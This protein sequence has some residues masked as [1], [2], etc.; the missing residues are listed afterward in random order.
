MASI[1]IRIAKQSFVVKGTDG[2]AP[3]SEVADRVQNKIDALL[4]EHPGMTAAK[5]A[6][7]AAMEFAS[8]A[9]EGRRIMDDYRNTILSK[10][11]EIL[12]RIER[13]LTPPSN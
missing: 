3:L 12:E 8:E 4:I 13:E 10:A 7:L 2:G 9:I 6:L 5:V 11:G 1:D